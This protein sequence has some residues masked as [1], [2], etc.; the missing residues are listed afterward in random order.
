MSDS[1]AR[2]L[3]GALRRAIVGT[4]AAVI[5]IGLV[6]AL[7][8]AIRQ[9]DAEAS[10]IA[11]N[12][13]QELSEGTHEGAADAFRR[14]STELDLEVRDVAA[15]DGATPLGP[16]GSYSGDGCR[17][18]AGAIACGATSTT[19]HVVVR[20]PLSRHASL[21]APVALA[22]LVT[23]VLSALLVAAAGR[24]STRRA[25]APLLALERSLHVPAPKGEPASRA[26][27]DAWGVAEVDAVASAL[28]GALVR[29]ELA[30]AREARFVADA[31]HELRTPLTRL[32]GQLELVAD[33]PALDD[34]ARAR[35]ASARR[36]VGGLV[37]LTEALLAMARGELPAREAVD[38]S[39]VVEAAVATFT[40]AERG[41]ISIEVPADALVEGA[42]A[43][44]EHALRNLVENALR[45]GAGKV[46]IAVREDG[47]RHVVDVT[48]EG[49][50]LAD[51]DLERVK[52]AFVRGPRPAPDGPAG[53][54]I[55][56]ALVEHVAE[57]HGGTLEL[58]NCAP[59]G[60]RARVSLP[61]WGTRSEAAPR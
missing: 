23:A 14:E 8:A 58:A 7:G 59:R 22:V 50:G 5:V 39:D 19:Y 56:L 52:V 43:L 44:L 46:T 13:A 48:D 36:S 28:K 3:D 27:A 4:S 51:A 9:D 61:K 57:L 33:D 11:R 21:A 18:A 16:A 25:L 55:G 15:W 60:L 47:G 31:A 26:I 12:L 24:R 34:E 42:P 29:A 10:A 1:I 41:R 2:V 32:R 30:S 17:L 20:T 38:L 6:A 37:S 35:L 54:G 45:H 40:D 53:A 49:E